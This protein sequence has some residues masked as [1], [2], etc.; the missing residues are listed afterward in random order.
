MFLK[1][2]TTVRIS[3]RYLAHDD[4]FNDIQLLFCIIFNNNNIIIIITCAS[5]L[6]IIISVTF[7][8]SRDVCRLF[9]RSL[10]HRLK[11]WEEGVIIRVHY[12]LLFA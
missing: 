1:G 7:F 2:P 10:K 3:V 11:V 8:V 6:H 9:G 12:I 5:M 4:L